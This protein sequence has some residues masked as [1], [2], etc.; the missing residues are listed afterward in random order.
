LD[1]FTVSGIPSGGTLTVMADDSATVLLNGVVLLAEATSAGNTY[2]TCSDFGIGCVLPTTINLPA[3]L[4]QTGSN[5]L[6]F[7]VAQRDGS[8]FGLDYSGIVLDPLSVAEPGTGFLALIGLLTL[9]IFGFCL[10]QSRI[11]M[12]AV[13]AVQI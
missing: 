13:S 3:S 1:V 10:E 8:S 6:E 9:A 7:E 12:Q 2:A 4:L 11:T 5:T